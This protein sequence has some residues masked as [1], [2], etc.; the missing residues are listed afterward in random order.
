MLQLSPPFSSPHTQVKGATLV[1]FSLCIGVLLLIVFGVIEVSRY[2]LVRSLLTKGVQDAVYYAQRAPEFDR[3]QLDNVDKLIID[4]LKSDISQI[5]ERLPSILVNPAAAM[6]SY[7][8]FM[9]F[10][11][12][13]S[14]P[15][16][17]L[18]LLPGEEGDLIYQKEGEPVKR[19]TIYNPYFSAL[20][21]DTW[22]QKLRDT[23]IKIVMA[24]VF[25]PIVPLVF[26]GIRRVDLIV[27][28]MAFRDIPVNTRIPQ[29]LNNAYA[30]TEDP[31]APIVCNPPK[32]LCLTGECKNPSCSGGR[33][34][35]TVACDCVDSCQTPK[36]NC[37]DALNLCV[38]PCPVGKEPKAGTQCSSCQ[39]PQSVIDNCL[40]G[41]T[42][43]D[44]GYMAGDCTCVAK[45]CPGNQI[46]CL[47]DCVPALKECEY[48]DTSGGT[49]SLVT[50][51]C[52][53]CGKILCG[54]ECIEQQTAAACASR[55]WWETY[56]GH[57]DLFGCTDEDHKAH[58]YVPTND[59]CDCREIVS[60]ECDERSGCDYAGACGPGYTP[61][62][63]T[64]F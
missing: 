1:E 18:V 48:Y 23:P 41:I 52:A 33:P 8:Y 4:T 30:P 32:V 58:R 42:L 64:C 43:G 61:H 11:Q 53:S 50:N 60:D 46:K 21:P 59:G 55:A 29:N 17:V 35:D 16:N 45:P 9:Q 20:P 24:V 40:N 7:Q 13:E 26:V 57:F 36:V 49:C 19:L 25:K 12:R 27:S 39:C 3:D 5:A 28:E 22:R 6:G 14:A 47:G 62:G 15:T 38:Y 10:Q 54:G 56:C 34:F 63:L 31:P 51:D 2:L 44:P 37:F